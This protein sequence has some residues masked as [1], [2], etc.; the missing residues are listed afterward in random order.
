MTQILIIA[1][2]IFPAA[3]TLYM[4]AVFIVN[5]IREYERRKQWCLPLYGLAMI[6]GLAGF[7]LSSLGVFK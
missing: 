4:L 5:P 3:F 6:G 1:C 2:L 7:I